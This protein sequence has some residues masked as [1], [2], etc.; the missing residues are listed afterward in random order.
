MIKQLVAILFIYLATCGAWGI[1]GATVLSRTYSSDT[2]NYQAVS[3]LW[4]TA[5]VQSAPNVYYET[6]KQVK[7]T[8][9][10][11]KKTVTEVVTV[12]ETHPIPLDQSTIKA[13]INLQHRQ[14]GLLWYSSYKVHYNS[15]YRATNSTDEP[16]TV[17]ISFELPAQMAI[18]DNF[19][20]VI[21]QKEIKNVSPSTQV[22]G[23]SSTALL[24]SVDIAPGASED[25]S[26]SYD[27]QGLDTW[28][29]KFGND[30]SQVK[31]FQLTLT[32]NFD[33]IDFPSGGMSPTDKKKLATGW[34]L[35]WNYKNLLTGYSV[36]LS[37]PAKLNPGPW[38]SKVTFFA[39]VSL[40]LFFFLLFVFTTIKGI[41]V[42]P[43]NYFFIG[44]AFFSFHLLMD[45]LVDS[46]PVDLA[47]VISSVVSIFLVVSY[48]RLVVSAKFALLE[49]GISQ[50]VYLVLFSYT[51]FYEQ[52]TGLAITIMCILTLFIMMQFTGRIDWSEVFKRAATP[53]LNTV[54]A[55]NQPGD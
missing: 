33:A 11:D 53:K 51:F 43:M 41:R 21:G 6:K 35:T 2:T 15:N 36:G 26:I 52:Y 47:F 5:Q 24:Q 18:Y 39:P 1:L 37:M 17:F 55:S 25:F 3:Q 28:T 46:I 54:V 42:H 30:V 50:L 29:Y 7:Q 22:G 34:Q 38:V 27:S 10:K 20:M 14:K 13:D 19:R 16:R 45:Y 48:M 32:T 9:V 31:N 44:A 23:S 49:V 8:S 40:F 4:G 12:T